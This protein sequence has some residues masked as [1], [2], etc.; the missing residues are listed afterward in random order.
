MAPR[1][2]HRLSESE[3]ESHWTLIHNFTRASDPNTVSLRPQRPLRSL[4]SSI[5]SLTYPTIFQPLST[6][7]MAS[8]VRVLVAPRPSYRRSNSSSSMISTSTP[9]QKR[10]PII[11]TFHPR[12]R[13]STVTSHS[14]ASSHHSYPRERQVWTDVP[15]YYDD[16]SNARRSSAGSDYGSIFSSTRRDSSDSN[17]SSASSASSGSQYYSYGNAP[18]KSTPSS[19]TSRSRAKQRSDFAPAVRVHQDLPASDMMVPLPLPSPPVSIDSQSMYSDGSSID[20]A[21]LVKKERER[22]MTKRRRVRFALA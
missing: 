2:Q 12:P 4:F 16:E 21:A 11:I 14:Q 9:R 19:S 6:G 3:Q 15:H 8:S 1:L 7:E 10:S 17:A 22:E 18:I 20:W 5:F 13:H